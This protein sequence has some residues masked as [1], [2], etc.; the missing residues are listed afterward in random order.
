MPTI[1]HKIITQVL[2]FFA[3]QAGGSIDKLKAMKLVFLADRY[4]IRKYGRLTTRDTYYAMK[5][6]P[7]PSATKNIADANTD[8]LDLNTIDY[9]SQYIALDPTNNKIK[10]I[11]EI[12]FDFLSETDREALQFSWNNFSKHHNIKLARVI[13]HQYP[14]WKNH[15]EELNHDKRVLITTEDFLDEPTGNLDNCYDLDNEKKD[16]L[17]TIIAENEYIESLWG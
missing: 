6:G 8:Y 10:S 4:H 17:K 12:D 5:L 2:N 9:V 11:K 7:V 3:I 13:S 15:K 1:K 16:T 14:E